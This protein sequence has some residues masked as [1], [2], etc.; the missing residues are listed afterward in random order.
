VSLSSNITRARWFSPERMTPAG[1]NPPTEKGDVWSFGS[2]GVEVFTG[3]DP[4][5]S[6]QDYYV[7]ILLNG[8]TPHTGRD[9]HGS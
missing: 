6:H 8:G 7:P 1:L 5:S 3:Q 4:Y 9:I 2:L